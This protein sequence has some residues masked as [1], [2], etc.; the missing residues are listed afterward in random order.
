MALK[1]YDP[2]KSDAKL[3]TYFDPYQVHYRGIRNVSTPHGNNR[4]T[5]VVQHDTLEPGVFYLVRRNHR[6]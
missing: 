5:F 2:F 4:K 1:K 3:S 6:R